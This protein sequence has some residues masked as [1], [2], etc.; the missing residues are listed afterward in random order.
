M[1]WGFSV[2]ELNKVASATLFTDENKD[3]LAKMLEKALLEP[4]VP[5]EPAAA[6]KYMEQV[7]V[8]TATDNRTDIELFQMVQLSSSESTYVMRFALFE[9]HQAIGLDIMDAENGQFFI[10][11]SCPI[12]QL[13]EP[14]LN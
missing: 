13:A 6:Q 7:A 1:K 5:M 2:S 3:L 8:R 14:T 4:L 9:N 10:P 12:C 11:E